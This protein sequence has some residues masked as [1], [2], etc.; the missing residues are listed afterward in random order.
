MPVREA[1]VTRRQFGQTA[2]CRSAHLWRASKH[3]RKND[4]KKQKKTNQMSETR[5]T[6][7]AIHGNGCEARTSAPASMRPAASAVRVAVLRARPS[8]AN[9]PPLE[10][11][12]ALED[13]VLGDSTVSLSGAIEVCVPNSAASAASVCAAIAA[14][15]RSSRAAR[16]SSLASSLALLQSVA[17]ASAV[18]SAKGAEAA[19]SVAR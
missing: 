2:A 17:A 12:S 16:A 7:E 13:S 6:I 11:S 9:T 19:N 4:E 14:L 10:L 8:R 18:A 1:G 3:T 15:S 5:K